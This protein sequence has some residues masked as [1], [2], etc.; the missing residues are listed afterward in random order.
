[1]D[2][3]ARR[4]IWEQPVSPLFAAPPEERARRALPF[5]RELLSAV[6]GGA[7]FLESLPALRMCI[8]R[9]YAR[10]ALRY[11]AAPLNA[12]T[13]DRVGDIR[14]RVCVAQL[15]VSRAERYCAPVRDRR[16]GGW[17]VA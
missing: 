15:V 7:T 12:E 14:L 8:E 5:L 13:I 4:S 17:R 10:W 1:M 11:F 3:G 16:A 6:E 9:E 2:S